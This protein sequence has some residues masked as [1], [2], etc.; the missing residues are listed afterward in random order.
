MQI[1]NIIIHNFRTIKHQNFEIEKYSILIGENNAGK[2]NVIRALR[3]FYEEMKYDIKH[4]FPKFSVD[5]DESRI[6]IEFSI[7]DEEKEWLKTEYQTKDNVLKVR[8]ILKWL[9]TQSGQSNIYWYENWN[10]STNLFYGAKNISAAK[11]WKVIYIPELSKID[12]NMK[13]SWP[14]PLREMINFVIKK[15]IKWSPSFDGLEKNFED[16]NKNF[17]REEAVDGNSITTIENDINWELWNRWVK[18]WLNIN[19]IQVDDMVKNLVSTS[20]KDLN[21][22]KW[23]NEVSID[24]FWQWLQRHLIYTLIKLSAKYQDIST[25]K[26]KDFNPDFTFILF[27]E[28]ELFLHP[29]QQD[30]MNHNLRTL[31]K[32]K[33]QQI[34]ITTH[35]PIFISKNIDDI[36]SLLRLQKYGPETKISQI[37][38]T[39]IQ[40]LFDDNN[41]F[42][43]YF[44]ELL[45]DTTIQQ[46]IKNE[47]ITKNL[48]SRDLHDIG[49]NL[50]KEQLKYLLWLDAERTACFFA[51]HVIICEWP[52]EKIFIDYLI[53]T[54]W[55]EFKDKNIYIIDAWWKFAIHRYMNLF[56]GLGISHSVLMDKDN[57][58]LHDLINNFIDWKKNPSTKLIH[59][60]NTDLEWFLWITQAIR[61]DQKPMNVLYHYQHDLIDEQKII[62]F[63]AIIESL[64]EV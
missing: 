34:M 61:K 43:V 40:N 36:T 24:S 1:K 58:L 42:F 3:V 56:W 4:D 47:I 7:T 50:D 60:F 35:C 39:D 62:D 48:W 22:T 9:M 63:R 28:P 13:M 15:V 6:E 32:E 23:S 11:L 29:A 21:L 59:K 25:K 16:F 18:F 37:K 33:W 54:T 2:S 51:K 64:L 19:P 27:E 5:D 8:K 20:I 49:K 55:T 17:K 10:L 30:K 46:N 38:N 26:T 53:N 52:S 31:S 41:S 44:S 57:S 12:D 45:A 14:S